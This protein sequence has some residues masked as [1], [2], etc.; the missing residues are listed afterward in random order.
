[1]ATDSGSGDRSLLDL[2]PS[3]SCW[4]STF[5]KN[6]C[7]TPKAVKNLRLHPRLFLTEKR[8][9]PSFER[10]GSRK[11]ASGEISFLN[12]LFV[13]RRSYTE[14]LSAFASGE[15]PRTFQT[16]RKRTQGGLHNQPRS[17]V[18]PRSSIHC[19]GECAQL[20]LPFA[21]TD[22]INC[23]SVYVLCIWLHVY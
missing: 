14:R 4:P 8:W 21:P 1:M 11:V 19:Q 6:P 18:N 5:F 12:I 15:W 16:K 9:V 17:A 3:R 22:T 20:Y 2:G 23:H 10:N 7:L 13:D